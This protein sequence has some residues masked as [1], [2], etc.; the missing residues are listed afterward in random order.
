[1]VW[2]HQRVAL[3]VAERETGFAVKAQITPRER[4]AVARPAD[5]VF[6][7][8]ANAQHSLG[9]ELGPDRHREPLVDEDGI[10]QRHDLQ[11]KQGRCVGSANRSSELFVRSCRFIDRRQEMIGP[12]DQER[13]VGAEHDPVLIAELEHQ[14]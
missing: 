14:A 11:A 1:M 7:E 3:D 5:N 13:V 12:C 9:F 4:L 8:N 2:T 10:R 6:A